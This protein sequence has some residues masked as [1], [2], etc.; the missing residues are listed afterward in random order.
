MDDTSN[1]K[2]L[3]NRYNIK[4]PLNI[5]LTMLVA[6]LFGMASYYINIIYLQYDRGI[7]FPAIVNGLF[8]MVALRLNAIWSGIQFDFDHETIEFPGGQISAN[9][10]LDYIN[11]LFIFQYFGRKRIALDRISQ[12]GQKSRRGHRVFG[13]KINQNKLYYG[14]NII[15]NFG[16]ATIW[17]FSQDKCEEAYSAIRQVNHMGSPIN[18]A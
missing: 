9:S 14:L 13:L 4:D 15:G 8:F 7:T 18:R 6:F 1:A 2:V 16:G 10:V 17:F 3:T 5:I 11:P 12:I